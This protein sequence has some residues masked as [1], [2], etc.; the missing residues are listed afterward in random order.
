MVVVV[1]VAMTGFGL[2]LGQ[3]PL[4][5]FSKLVINEAAKSRVLSTGAR[6]TIMMTLHSE[7]I[8]QTDC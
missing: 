4:G 1:V 8:L 5:F 7:L 6:L 3:L 2:D